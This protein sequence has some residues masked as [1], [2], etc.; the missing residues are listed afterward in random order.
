[1]PHLILCHKQMMCF[2]GLE[3]VIQE[4]GHRFEQI[5][6]VLSFKMEVGFS[7]LITVQVNLV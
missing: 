5:G 4:V 7:L 2:V 3:L 1:M 6:A